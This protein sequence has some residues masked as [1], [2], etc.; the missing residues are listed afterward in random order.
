VINNL[1]IWWI[2]RAHRGSALLWIAISLLLIFLGWG[3]S[4]AFVTSSTRTEAHAV[5][6][7]RLCQVL[8]ES[9][10][11]EMEAQLG[12]QVNDLRSPT[13]NQLRQQVL[14]GEPGRID[15]ASAVQ[16]K[17]TQK[18][19][20]RSPFVGFKVK[21]RCWVEFQR[22][23]DNV[24]Y[25]KKGLA[26]F[27][28]TVISPG[29]IRTIS[30]QVEL[31]RW[32][33]T[34]LLTMPRPFGNYG[35]FVA[36]AT[37]LT[38]VAT[39]NRLRDEAAAI[40]RKVLASI[41]ALVDR[42]PSN[43]RQG[44]QNLRQETFDPEAPKAMPDPVSLPD[45]SALYGLIQTEGTQR[46]SHLDLAWRLGVLV[47]KAATLERKLASVVSQASSTDFAI[48]EELLKI[49]REAAEAVVDP[50]F[51]LWAFHQGYKVLPPTSG[52]PYQ[53]VKEKL[54]K[55][56]YDYFQ[57]RAHWAIRESPGKTDLTSDFLELASRVAQGVVLVENKSRP[58]VLS[59]RIRGR[60]VIVVGQ[61]GVTIRDLNPPPNAEDLLTV[62]ACSGPV[63]VSG[64][65]SVGLVLGV[66]PSS[67]SAP[68]LSMA[69]DA[70]IVGALLMASLPTGGR[71]DGEVQ[72]SDLQM[73]GFAGFDGTDQGFYDRYFVGLSPQVYYRRVVRP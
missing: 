71:L 53:E 31:A 66:P 47:E 46:L 52:K 20:E 70:R 29:M 2:R 58:L 36:D 40:A 65:N 19:I 34:T 43:V 5:V 68:T 7:A 44:Y 37:G 16:L 51:E 14:A 9:G 55:L 30:R 50:L 41:T 13:A 21:G 38:D 63:S 61:G 72:R 48:Q 67:L 60:L 1:N 62:V 56:Q 73:S 45:G 10:V 28:V 32:I 6:E 22:Q 35:L 69:S 3:L 64:Q 24:P 15:L 11:A 23:I 8:A 12:Y 25:E 17:E 4:R 54:Y 49:A 26:V 18:L 59:G 27:S 57:L 33:K 39:T 42:V